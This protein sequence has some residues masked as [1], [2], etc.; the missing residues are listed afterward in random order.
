[1]HSKLY[2]R[3]RYVREGD[4]KIGFHKIDFKIMEWIKVVLGSRVVDSCANIIKFSCSIETK[5]ILVSFSVLHFWVLLQGLS[6]VLCL[7]S[8]NGRTNGELEKT[9]TRRDPSLLKITIL[10]FA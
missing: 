2:S 1:M 4:I 5:H 9:V 3:P 8:S 10:K 6:Y 7:L